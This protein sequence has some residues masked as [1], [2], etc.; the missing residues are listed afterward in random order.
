MPSDYTQ[1]KI[2]AIRSYQTD[3]VYIG[4]TIQPL[5]QRMSGHRADYKCFLKT[6]KR[7]MTSFELL[8]YDDAYIELIRKCP[9][10]TREELL[11]E[12]GIEIRKAN[13]VN[14]VVAGRTKAEW[15]QENPEKRKEIDKNYRENHRDLLTEKRKA[16]RATN[17]EKVR[18]ANR[19]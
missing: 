12:E 8:K 14:M 18:E 13:C 17:R 15:L 10:E 1:G 11:R 2:Y 4:S 7:Y 3:K 16:Y 19:K 5:S 9:C 6:S